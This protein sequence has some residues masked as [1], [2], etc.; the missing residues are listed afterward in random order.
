[1]R[2]LIR[3]V[4][5]VG[6]SVAYAWA[7]PVLLPEDDGLG[8]GLLY[9]VVVVNVSGLW[10]LWDG[11]RGTPIAA[12]A[13]GWVMVGVAVGAH[14]PVRIWLT[15]GRDTAALWSDLVLLTPF[16]AGLVAAPALTGLLVGRVARGP[17]PARVGAR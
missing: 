6:G 1:M 16:L 8:A 9:F 12:G 3:L 14:V 13:A 11:L 4:V 2:I 17:A 7:A 10:G 5:M 15:E